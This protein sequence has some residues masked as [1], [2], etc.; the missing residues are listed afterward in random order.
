MEAA[1]WLALRARLPRCPPPRWQPPPIAPCA[2]LQ[3]LGCVAERPTAEEG[4]VLSSVH[5][6]VKVP[7]DFEDHVGVNNESEDG[8]KATDDDLLGRSDAAEKQSKPNRSRT[9]M[10]KSYSATATVMQQGPSR[11]PSK[12]KLRKSTTLEEYVSRSMRIEKD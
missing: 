10:Q 4:A 6:N 12:P 3:P 8:W 11:A 5:V 2:R 9:G 7:I 1:P